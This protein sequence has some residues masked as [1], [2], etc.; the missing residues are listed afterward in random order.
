[1][2]KQSKIKFNVLAVILII[3]FGAALTPVTLQNDTFYTIK[4]G[5]H[6]MQNGID[7]MDPFSWHENLPYTYPH[8]LYDVITYLIYN[9]G[10]YSG[11]YILTIFFASL[12]G[13]IMYFLNVKLVKNQVTS[14]IITIASMYFIRAYI[15]ARAQ[16]VT[17][18]LFLLTIY[19][20][21]NFLETRKKR[22]VFGLFIIPTI[23]ANVH[24]AVW[25]FFFVLFLPYIGEYVIAILSNLGISIRKCRLKKIKSNQIESEEQK[26]KI[27]KIENDITELEERKQ[28]IKENAYKINIEK[29]DNVKYLIIIMLVCVL[30]G[31]LTPLHGTPYTYLYDTL[32]GNTTQFINEHLPL[33]L[34]ENME[35]LGIILVF[36]IILMFTDT[37]IRLRDLFMVGGLLYLSFKTRRQTSMFI[38]IC[39][40]IL[41]RLIVS[42]FKK[43]D[44]KGLESINKGITTLIGK[45][46]TCIIV[47][48]FSCL[49][50]APKRY[51]T[52][53]DSSSYP[54]E[55]V[56]YI[57][58]N[59]D[60]EN[61]RLY[62]EYNYG[63]YLLLNDIPVFIDSRCDLYTKEYNKQK[64][65]FSDFI[66]TNNIGV[67][68]E[69]KMEEYEITHVI[70]QKNAKLNMFI[71]RDENYKE[72]YSDD[73]FCI[74]ERLSVYLNEK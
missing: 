24:L 65:I 34:I 19:C 66:N 30:T 39:S 28:K 29:N 15:T 64:D 12:M 49:I 46:L 35:F 18:I 62:N 67:Y 61:I 69:E 55:A 42:L 36:L 60:L 22:Y 45:L 58:D 9:I 20:I 56:Q 10:G 13:I 11:V 57:K 43:Y 33:T 70:L 40:L 26:L 23:I 5:E 44:E 6:I 1:M 53:I 72:L 47:L 52:F 21:E 63:S 3:I 50:F 54:V 74:Y 27:E 51:N 14:F 16:L 7:M 73:Y 71:S 4:I 48:V 25:P 32:R 68:Y 37:K 8:W 2:D 17:F 31:L 59:L 38:L 41:N